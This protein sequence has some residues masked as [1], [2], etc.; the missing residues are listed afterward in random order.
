MNPERMHHY[1]REINRLRPALVEAYA[2]SAYELAR[3]IE[4]E[5]FGH[6]H[7]PVAIVTSAGMLYPFMRET[8][9]RAF[10][11][12]V[13]NRYGSREVGIIACQCRE[14]DALHVSPWTIYLEV[15]DEAGKTC[16][17]RSRGP[18]SHDFARQF[19]DAAYSV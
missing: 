15:A 12:P 10:H 14:R 7:P 2:Q 3:Y 16:S 19:Y 17:S 11:A 1:V 9:E 4:A 6:P 8:I 18:H 5:R 13:F